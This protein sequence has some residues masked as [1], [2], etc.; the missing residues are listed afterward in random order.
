[1]NP[2]HIF[3]LR[4]GA[5]V[6][7]FPGAFDSRPRRVELSMLLVLDV[8]IRLDVFRASLRRASTGG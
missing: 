1:M 4:I 3:L 8:E 7:D 5:L 6:I 2:G